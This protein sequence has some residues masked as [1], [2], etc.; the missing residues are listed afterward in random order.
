MNV[1]MCMRVYMYVHVAFDPSTVQGVENV[2]TRHKPQLTDIL[3]ALVKGKLKD[4]DFPFVGGG[5]FA[6]R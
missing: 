5:P 4:R 6:E 1:D 2:Y 3:D